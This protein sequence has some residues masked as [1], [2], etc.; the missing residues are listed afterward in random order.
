MKLLFFWILFLSVNCLWSQNTSTIHLSSQIPV[1][2]KGN[3]NSCSAF[4]VAAVLEV[5][6]N[7]PKD[8]S[9]NFLYAAQK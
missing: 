6:P 5:L 9:E 7:M 4:G 3:G 2:N 1:K 8:I